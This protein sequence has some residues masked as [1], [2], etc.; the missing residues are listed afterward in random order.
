MKI[1][2]PNHRS[3]VASTE[4]QRT[5]ALAHFYLIRPFL[6]DGVPLTHIAA[7]HQLAVRTLR[8]WVQQYRAYGLIGLSTAP[9]KDQGHRRSVTPELQHVIE[10][11]ALQKPRRTMAN[12]HR[13]TVR[14]SREHNWTPPSYSTVKRIIQQ[15]DPQ[16]TTLAHEGSKAYQEAFDLMYRHQASAPN[17]V[18]QADHSLLSIVVLNE[19]GKPAKPWLTIILDDYSRAVAGY[20]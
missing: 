6:E 3:L 18:W 7:E 5:Q 2:S 13:E 15:I 8:R 14:M 11:L 17:E 10:G 1:T 16:L 9:R 19:H 12:I 20:S 4:T